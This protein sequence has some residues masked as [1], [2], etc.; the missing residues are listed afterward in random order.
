MYSEWA[1]CLAVEFRTIGFLEFWEHKTQLFCFFLF[2]FLFYIR[3]DLFLRWINRDHPGAWAEGLIADKFN[4]PFETIWGL[5]AWPN[6]CIFCIFY[7]DFHLL[8]V[9]RNCF[10]CSTSLID[11]LFR[12]LM[13]VLKNINRVNLTCRALQASTPSHTLLNYLS[14]CPLRTSLTLWLI[15]SF[16]HPSIYPSFYLS[17]LYSLFPQPFF[18][19]VLYSSTLLSI[20]HFPIFYR[21]QF[22]KSTI[23]IIQAQSLGVSQTIIFK[24]INLNIIF[25]I[26]CLI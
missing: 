26:S 16:I 1:G 21:S 3:Y 10:C 19:P 13:N 5:K 22:S 8:R 25:S 14:T 4:V 17:H 12:V 6:W 9:F 23:H 20:C 2:F 15:Y 11:I 24:I 18:L 7:V